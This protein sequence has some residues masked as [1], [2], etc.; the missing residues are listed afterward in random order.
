MSSK[1]WW[2]VITSRELFALRKRLVR[3]L[4]ESFGREIHRE[5]EDL[6]Q[7][8]FL[9]LLRNKERVL[10]DDDG[11]FRYVRRVAKNAAL[12]RIKSAAVRLHVPTAHGVPADTAAEKTPT[13]Q[14]SVLTQLEKNEEIRQIRKIFC[15]LDDLDRLVLWSYVVDGVSIN[16]IARQL[17]ISWQ[18]VSHLIE[19]SLARFRRR[20][21]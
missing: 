2:S 17:G 8:A 18:Q 11:L 10:P 12:D 19:Q 6:V 16:A 14:P 1:P 20:L 21:S 7:H 3:Y 4:S 13:V 9:V 15:E 5:S